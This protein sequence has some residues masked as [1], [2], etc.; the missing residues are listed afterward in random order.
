MI[1]KQ[2]RIAIFAGAALLNAGLS[3]QTPPDYRFKAETLATGMAQPMELELAPDGRIFFN[4]INGKLR[5]W[6]SGTGI[7]EAG[8]L[9]VFTAQENGFLGFALDPKFSENSFIYLYY[10]P[11]NHTGQRLSRFVMRGDLLDNAS[12]KVVLEFPEQRKD[13]CHHAG[14]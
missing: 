13:C 2:I 12:E 9:P 6:K 8:K 10:S 4:E 7:V 11:T 3:A 5:I 14:S 1:S